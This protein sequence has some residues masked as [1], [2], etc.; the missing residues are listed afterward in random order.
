MRTL[1]YFL[2]GGLGFLGSLAQAEFRRFERLDLDLFVVPSASTPERVTIAAH[3]RIDPEW[4]IYWSNPG[5]SGAAPKFTAQGGASVERVDWPYPERIALGDL[6]NFGYAHEVVIPLTVRRPPGDAPLELKLE[7]L[8]CK[9][10]CLPGFGDFRVD[11]TRAP[12][13]EQLA[14]YQKF[15]ARVPTLH[16]TARLE[17]VTRTPAEITLGWAQAKPAEYSE[18]Q[19]YPHDGANFGTHATRVEP[20]DQ[21]RGVLLHLALSENAIPGLKHARF[22]VVAKR[23]GSETREAFEADVSLEPGRG[24]FLRALAFAFLGG[25]ILNLMPCVFPVLS[26]KV[27][28]FLREGDARETRRSGWAYTAGVLASFAILAG[29]LLSL[30]AAGQ[31]VGW[32]FQLQSPAFVLGV[33]VLFF[34]LGL[35][36]LGAF[37]IGTGLMNWAGRQGARGLFSGSFGT[38]VLAVVIAT[39][40]TAPFM[41]TALGLTLLLPPAQAL[42]VFLSLGLGLALPILLLGYLPAA[43]LRR[44]PRPGAWMETLKQFFAFPLFATSLWLAWVLSMQRGTA[45]VFAFLGVNFAIAFL[46]WLARFAKGS[47]GRGGLVIL[48][49]A[50]CGLAFRWV[51]QETLP[52][53]AG[54]PAESAWEKFS[55]EVVEAARSEGPVFVDFTASWCLSCQ[56]NKKSVLETEAIQALF[57]AQKVRLFR[58]DWTNKDPTITAALAKFGR[59]SVPVYAFYPASQDAKLLPELLTPQ[60]VRDLFPQGGTP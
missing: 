27:F 3:F 53:N 23:N 41:G 2:L 45:G 13:P 20:L 6:A 35:N 1:R 40:C 16:P 60:I 30:R 39:P 8:V 36:F 38:G 7:W 55:P 37:E 21:G 57:R 50:V 17:F 11:L 4:H 32:G 5:D 24:E 42:A 47:K 56:W 14:V 31:S 25:V 29:A 33:G 10:E 19:V 51:G 9:E 43:L 52:V 18:I 22:T 48:G 54:A 15:L 44:M 59:N 12:Q 28:A 58:A 34:L 26:L 49:L 46:I